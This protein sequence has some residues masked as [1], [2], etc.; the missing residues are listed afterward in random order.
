MSCVICDEPR[1]WRLPFAHNPDVTRWRAEAGDDA[2]YEWR[3]CRRCGNAY[4][5]HQPRLAVLQRIWNA[6]RSDDCLATDAKDAAWSYRRA[7]SRAGAARSFRL[8]APLAVNDRRRFLD[9]GCGLGE[10]VRIFADNGWDAEGID[11]DPST[12]R[13]HREL[14]IR[15][16]IGQFEQ[17]EATS[18]YDLIHIAHAIYFITDPMAFIRGVRARLRPGGLFCIVLANLMANTDPAQPS[19]VHTFFPTASSMRYALSC[20]GFETILCRRLSG[21]T[22]IAAQPASSVARPFV[23]PMAIRVLYNTK[24]LR[25]ALLGRPY[26]LGKQAVKFLIGCNY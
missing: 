6:S 1:F 9:I 12:A 23:S 15:V 18:E 25:Y 13:F 20:A 4:P 10:T 19:Y 11:T 21:S 7:I 26:I 16:H 14:G 22:F 17:I 3:L 24:A 2:D 8:F 5:S